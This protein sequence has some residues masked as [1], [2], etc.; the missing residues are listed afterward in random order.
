[1]FI[2]YAISHLK[3]YFNQVGVFQN[4]IETLKKHVSMKIIN[5]NNVV[6]RLELKA[7]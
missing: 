6:G 5:S 1:M 2:Y 3:P 4:G 7:T